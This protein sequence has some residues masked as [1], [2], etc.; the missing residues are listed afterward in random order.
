MILIEEAESKF[1][2]GST[3]L[4]ISSNNF[5][6]KLN[7]VIC[8]LD[9]FKYSPKDRNYE[10]PLNTLSYVVNNL[11]DVDDIMFKFIKKEEKEEPKLVVNYKTTPFD[12]QLEGIKYGLKN[13]KWLLLDTQGLGKSLQLIYLAEELKAQKD[14]KHCLVICG[15]N[16]LKM[17]WKKEIE[18]HSNLDSI[19]IGQYIDKYHRLKV[20]M[21]DD[22]VEFMKHPIKEFFLITNIET[23]RSKKFIDMVLKGPNKI[24]MIIFDE[25]H[26]AKGY[27]TLSAEGLLKLKAPY[28]VASSGTLIMNNPLDAY[29]P[30][31]WINKNPTGITNYKKTYCNF[32]T[33]IIGKIDSFKNMDLL[34]DQIQN[35]SIRRTKDTVFNSDSKHK[36][37][38]KTIIDEYLDMDDSQEK[39]YLDIVNGVKN[40]YMKVNVNQANIL[41]MITRLRQALVLPSILTKEIQIPSVKIDRCID[42]VEQIVSNGEKVVIFSNFKEPVYLLEKKLERFNPL[43]ATGD[44]DDTIVSNQV[45]MFQED[46]IHMVFIGT[47]SKIGTGITLNRATTSIFIDCPFTYALCEQCE[48]RIHRVNN[49][50]PV[51]IYYLWCNN[52][53]DSRIQKLVKTKMELSDYLVDKKVNKSNLIDILD[54]FV[55]EN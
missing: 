32:D 5:Y 33:R 55:K 7:E 53:F 35:C 3:S 51:T 2:G 4:F 9:I 1:L 31:K 38:P 42:L 11:T 30:L 21:I 29:I 39:F 47:S 43:V 40:D 8:S 45:K 20:G 46:D 50:H 24:D 27:N 12:Y 36:I 41:E 23:L 25:C 52:S 16:C 44:I 49:T 48:D 22:R 28:M 13:N 37:P 19:I 18:K 26:K 15:L 14:I 10:I 54:S 34:Q 6:P 17:N